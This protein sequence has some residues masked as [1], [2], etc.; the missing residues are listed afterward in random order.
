LPPITHNLGQFDTTMRSGIQDVLPAV[1][2][3]MARSIVEKHGSTRK[4]LVT[5][6]LIQSAVSRYIAGKGAAT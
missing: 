2:A 6:G 3:I 4:K 5:V 1:K